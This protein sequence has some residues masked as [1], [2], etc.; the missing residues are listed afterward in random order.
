L[1]RS[2]WK[3]PLEGG[4]SV[5]LSDGYRMPVYSPDNQL[6]VARS[7]LNSGNGDVAIFSANGGAP[8]KRLNIQV[9]EWQR[10][11]WLDNHTLS[12]IKEIGGTSNI[13]SYDINTDEAK[14]LTNF[15]GEQIFTYAW[16]PDYKEIVCQRGTKLSNVTIIGSEQ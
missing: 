11:Y 4:E 15:N 13:W 14:Q 10:L 7:P 16:S 9:M 5:K 2:V 12:F 3:V 8:L 6:I 1:G